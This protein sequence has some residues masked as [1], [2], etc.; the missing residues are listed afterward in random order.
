MIKRTATELPKT[1][2]SSPKESDSPLWTNKKIAQLLE[3]TELFQQNWRL[4]SRWIQDFGEEDCRLK[5]QEL[6]FQVKQTGWE[7]HEDSRLAAL[8]RGKR[9]VNWF[10][11]STMIMGRNAFQC[12]QRWAQLIPEHATEESWGN[13]EQKWIFK[14]IRQHGCSWKKIVQ[15]LPGRTQASLKSLFRSAI[16]K[17]KKCELFKFIKNMILWP[18]TSGKSKILSGVLENKCLEKFKVNK[19]SNFENRIKL[20]QNHFN[21]YFES[22]QRD[23]EKLT[24]LSQEILRHLLKMNGEDSKV[25]LILIKL[26]FGK[27]EM[28]LYQAKGPSNLMSAEKTKLMVFIKDYLA[29]KDRKH[30]AKFS[31]FNR[32]HSENKIV[33]QDKQSQIKSKIKNKI[34]DYKIIF[35]KEQNNGKNKKDNTGEEWKISEE[36]L[37]QLNSILINSKIPKKYI[38]HILWLKNYAPNSEFLEE[39]VNLLFAAYTD[40]HTQK[41]PKEIQIEAKREY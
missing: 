29:E 7:Q 30:D 4:I 8:V 13:R 20:L 11:V 9:D 3:F 33:I 16:K 18:E 23:F 34:E 31:I 38:E 37:V 14:M 32:N 24:R 21:A 40:K 2:L 1:K 22:L 5:F 26:V 27:E 25:D 35:E 12:R 17:L 19:I 28:R 39:F 41:N 36:T 10:E 6:S 15:L